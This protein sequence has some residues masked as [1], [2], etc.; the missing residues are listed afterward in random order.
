[1][2]DKVW[3]P[4]NKTTGVKYPPVDDAEKNRLNLDVATAGKYRFEKVSKPVTGPGYTPPQTAKAPEQK[5]K[6]EDPPKEEKAD[7][8]K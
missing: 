7:D 4:I 8:K 3:I 5:K 2:A 1:M 6:K